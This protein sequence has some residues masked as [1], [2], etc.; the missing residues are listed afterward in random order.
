MYLVCAWHWAYSERKLGPFHI[1]SDPYPL[2]SVKESQQMG[3]SASWQAALNGLCTIQLLHRILSKSGFCEEGHPP[4]SHW[5]SI[6]IVH[7]ANLFQV[8]LSTLH[9]REVSCATHCHFSQSHCLFWPEHMFWEPLFS[10]HGWWSIGPRPIKNSY[11]V[12]DIHN[13]APKMRKV[14]LKTLIK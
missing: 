14:D 8:K 5:E 2:S 7:P 13:V 10:Q 11:Y 3:N 1:L 12:S 6:P 9:L 4:H